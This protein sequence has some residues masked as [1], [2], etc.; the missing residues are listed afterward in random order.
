M[1]LLSQLSFGAPWI[2]AALAAIPVIYWLLRVTPPSPRRIVFPP[3]RFLL[4]LKSPEE[5]PARTPLWLLL[6]RLLAAAIVI[7]AL[8]EPVLNAAPA[9][10][11][12][13][14]LVLFVDNGWT[15]AHEWPAH[16]AAMTQAL[17]AAHGRPVA[18]VTT[19]DAPKATPQLLDAGQALKTVEEI[20][21]RPWLPDRAAAL[22]RLATI[23]FASMPEIVWLS[24]GIDHN[25]ARTTADNLAR[26]GTLTIFADAEPKAALALRPPENSATGFD[27]KI[28]RAEAKLVRDGRIAALDARGVLLGG[29]P[30]HFVPGAKETKAALALPLELRNEAERLTIAGEDSAGAVQLLDARFQRRPVG[31]VSGGSADIEQPLL[32]DVFYVE[33]ALAPYAEVRKG[34]I[35]QMLD[36]GIAMLVL[37][38][39]GNLTPAEHDR[40]AR[41]VEQGGVLLRFAGP[42]LAAHADDL[43]P[44]KLREGERLMG[45]AL[46][47]QE[48]QHLAPFAD[49]SPFHGL[50]IPD[51]VTVSRQVLAEP[52]IELSERS[53]ARLADGTPLV[54]GS[55]RGKGWIV[56]FHVAASPG[57]SS[58]PLSGLYVDMLRRTLALAEGM[59]PSAESERAAGSYPPLQALD[60]FGRLGKPSAEA[61]PLKSSDADSLLP[62][63]QHPPGLYGSEA[64]FIALNA[65]KKD[66]VLNPLGAIGRAVSVYSG[67]TVHELKGPLLALALALLLGDAL[68]SLWLRGHLDPNRKFLR[69]F[70]RAAPLVLLLLLAPQARADEA[71]NMASALDTRLAYVITGVPDVDAMS[72][73]GLYGLGLELKARTSYE[74]R[75]SDRRRYRERRPVFLSP[76]LLADGRARERS[77]ARR[78]RQDRRFH[79]FWRHDSVRHARSDPHG[80][81]RQ[82]VARRSHAATAAR[83]ARHSRRSSPCLPIT[84]SPRHFTCCRIFPAAG[85]A[86]KS[87]CRRCRPPVP[88]PGLSPRA[89]ATASRPSSSAAMIGRRPGP[90]D[91]LGQPIAA[92][93]P[94]GESQR[95]MAIRFG[96]NVVMYCADRQLQNR[97]GA[98]AGAAGT[99]GPREPMM[100][101]N[102]ATGI[103]FAPHLPVAALWLLGAMALGVIGVSIFARARGSWARAL[104]FAIADCSAC[105]SADRARDARAFVRRG[106]A[107]RGSLAKPG[108]RHAP[109]RR[110]TRAWRD[111]RAAEAAQG[112]RRC[113]KR[114][115][116]PAPMRARHCLPRSMRRSP[117]CRPTA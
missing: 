4:G 25:D 48:P 43:V 15:A 76:A 33:R 37:A 70:G 56:L 83:Q 112:R 24:D 58:L 14:P 61:L 96:I 111:A 97:P 62:G 53:W 73:A 52:S 115:C 2:L 84:F 82:H 19:A 91:A 41:F 42:R 51:D 27:V 77:F 89:A 21:P 49:D 40:V 36:S 11:N 74:P 9:T 20:A 106:G 46:T 116:R 108:H 98:R 55:A 79:A 26:I 69:V 93:T 23:H 90:C 30:F 64:G 35:E 101:G 75:R 104:A 66:T 10:A 6:L 13:G 88:M 8:A 94:G 80:N 63:P 60:G 3:V 32:S 100:G 38:D 34:T 28:A 16:E 81:F 99:A 7:T 87:G 45:S 18:I 17:N 86:A 59:K 57:W 47:W 110:R 114:R 12:S 5:T 71:K 44:V 65:V 68:V 50:A 29:A 105:Q 31:I 67:R 113:A 39:V 117:T 72:R 85:T 109:R 1:N 78:R 102:L 22:K 54:T 92:V 95:E 103:A 107:H